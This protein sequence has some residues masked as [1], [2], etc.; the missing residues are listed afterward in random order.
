MLETLIEQKIRPKKSLSQNFLIN[1]NAAK[2]IVESLNLKKNET[3]LEIG[4]GKGALTKHLI[5]KS[6]RVIGVEIDKRLCEFLKKRFSFYKNLEIIN[7][8]FLKIDFEK[9]ISPDKKIKVI[10]NLPY[11]I[12]SP[13]LALLLENKKRIKSAVLMVQKEVAQRI[14]AQPGN[15]NWS[16]LSIGIQLYSDPDILFKLKPSSFKPAPKVESTV[17]KLVFLKKPKVKIEDEVFFPRLVKAAFS[18]RRKMILNSV[19]ASLGWRKD[20]VLKALLHVGIDPTKRAEALTIEKLASF[21]SILSILK[22]K[23]DEIN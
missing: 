18:Q 16:P 4:P 10:G 1:E 22:Q 20:L 17:I 21:S 23:D 19:S 14:C 12:T 5:Y 3:V 8:D 11:Q 2:R 13:A 6:R 9:T 7:K 15:K